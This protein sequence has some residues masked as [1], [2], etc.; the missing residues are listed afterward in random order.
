MRGPY[1]IDFPVFHPCSAILLDDDED[2]LLALRS[3]LGEHYAIF[4]YSQPEKA[5]NR[6]RQ[7][8]Q[9]T[10]QNYDLFTSYHH[11]AEGP[12]ATPGDNL[13]LLKSS[14]LRQFATSNDRFKST[15][16]IIVDQVMPN[17]TGLQFCELI[18]DIPV[19]KI[20][21]TGKVAANEAIQ[22]FNDGLID[23]YISKYE[24]NAMEK[25]AL[26]MHQLHKAYLQDVL[27]PATKALHATRKHQFDQQQAT[28]LLGHVFNIFPYI[29]YYYLSDINGFLLCDSDG[30]RYILLCATRNDLME[31]ADFIEDESGYCPETEKLRNATH[32]AWDFT[33][34]LDAGWSWR[35]HL[36]KLI[37][38]AE[39]YKDIH[40]S[41]VPLEETPI[42]NSNSKTSWNTYRQNTLDLPLNWLE[43]AA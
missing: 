10:Q 31:I 18:Q 3:Y 36:N 25:V 11:G 4:G 43:K 38:P 8:W 37:Y 39:K 26:M 32:M 20:L 35:N 6:L 13:V 15:S 23:R 29:E 5:L 28:E 33:G 24:T 16:V 40:W 9:T 30:K 34:S 22:A 2:F 27:A 19:K 12:T 21:L 42:A 7:T 17:M 1:Q 41:L 14:K